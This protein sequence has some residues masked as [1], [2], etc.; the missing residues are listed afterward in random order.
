V[1]VPF[2][3]VILGTMLIDIAFPEPINEPRETVNVA[4]FRMDTVLAI[5]ENAPELNFR[6]TFRADVFP[7]QTIDPAKNFLLTLGVITLPVT[8]NTPGAG[9]NRRPSLK[10]K[11]FP[12]S[13]KAP[14]RMASF[15]WVK[16]LP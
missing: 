13:V 8:V 10:A 7:E 12:V 16:S 2:D 14:R 9:A 5:T 3:I 6:F 4:P 11:G 1:N 15:P